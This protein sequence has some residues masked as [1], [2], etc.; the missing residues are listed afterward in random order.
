MI[1][2]NLPP[3]TRYLAYAFIAMTL[4]S[5]IVPSLM[6][7][8]P[9][10]GESIF[11]GFQLWRLA[12]YPFFVLASTRALLNT[13]FTLM[14]LVFILMFFAGE[15]ETIIHSRRFGMALAATVVLGGFIY[16]LIEPSAALYGPSVVTMFCLAGFAYLWPKREISLF[17][18][19]FVKAW[20]IALALYV[21]SIIPMQGVSMEMTPSNL[22]GP[23]FGALAAL[24]YFHVTYKQYSFGRSLI[25][26]LT[27]TTSS[28]K[29]RY[30][31]NEPKA[32]QMKIDA[33]LDKISQSGMQ[34]LSK[35]ER[36]F[37]LKNSK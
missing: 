1:F 34:S 22:F 4:I 21:I 18:I 31:P 23:T 35:D 28:K 30:D 19:F 27:P 37:L 7:Y 26:S 11:H 2:K 33:I 13:I 20:I 29:V 9:V 24:I 6:L 14:W 3:V 25:T 32:V 8:L 17:G 36:E 15:L 12:T 5:L 10:S 16:A